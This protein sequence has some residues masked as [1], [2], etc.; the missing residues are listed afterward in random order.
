MPARRGR[1]PH[2]CLRPPIAGGVSLVL[3]LLRRVPLRL[4][5]RTLLLGILYGAGRFAFDFLREDTRR[6]GL[7]GSQMTAGAVIVVATALLV[8]RR[9]H[10]DLPLI[11]TDRPEPGTEGPGEGE[12]PVDDERRSPAAS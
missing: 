12:M 11:R 8:W 3:V 10:G 4:G 9:R 5:E 6:F 1:P 7:T 2:R